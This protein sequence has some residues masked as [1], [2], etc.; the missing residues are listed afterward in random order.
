MTLQWDEI[1]VKTIKVNP[2]LISSGA[3]LRVTMSLKISLVSH[4]Y[5]YIY[6]KATKFVIR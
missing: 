2:N 3:M 5:I 1:H 6:I 4:T